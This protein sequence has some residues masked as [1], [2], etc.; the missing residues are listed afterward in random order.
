[1]L[2]C[3]VLNKQC[4]MLSLCV[5]AGDTYLTKGLSAIVEFVSI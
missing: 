4:H 3:G 2:S 5:L 1:M